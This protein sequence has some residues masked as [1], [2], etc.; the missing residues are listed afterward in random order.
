MMWEYKEFQ[1]LCRITRGASP[2]PIQNWITNNSDGVNWIKISDATS[3]KGR[4]IE[5]TNEQILPEGRE[6][7]VE[8]KKG[9]L[10]LSNSAS[11]G[12]PKF[13]GLSACIHD[14]WLLLRNLNADPLFIYYLLLN[15]RRI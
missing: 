10:I 9:D 14:G 6:K 3:T 11:P 15:E 1:N 7:S 2:R 4:T 8:V 5:H 12:I 13:V